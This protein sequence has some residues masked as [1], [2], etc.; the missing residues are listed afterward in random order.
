MYRFTC[1]VSSPLNTTQALG[2]SIAM[3]VILEKRV[4]LKFSMKNHTD[5]ISFHYS[6]LAFWHIS[7][8][9]KPAETASLPVPRLGADSWPCQP[10]LPQLIL[11]HFVYP[12]VVWCDNYNTGGHWGHIFPPRRKRSSDISAI[13]HTLLSATGIFIPVET[14]PDSNCALRSNVMLQAL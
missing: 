2:W 11:N 12:S 1:T 6:M 3:N 13:W 9:E 4:P 10:L 5:Q 14:Q 7:S 8:K